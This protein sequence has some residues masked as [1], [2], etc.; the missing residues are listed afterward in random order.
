MKNDSNNN[1]LHATFTSSFFKFVDD[2]EVR[3][4]HIALK[5]HIRS[6]SRS[7]YSDFGVN[8]RRVKEFY[9]RLSQ[10]TST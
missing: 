3:V 5:L 6:A 4:D 1:Y 7:G 8:K 10:K 2:F 9:Q